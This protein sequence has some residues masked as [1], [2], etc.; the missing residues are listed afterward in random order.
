MFIK[1]ELVTFL[2]KDSA[3]LSDDFPFSDNLP[4][5]S[6]VFRYDSGIGVGH[7]VLCS[8][9]KIPDSKIG[10]LLSVDFLVQF[11]EGQ[12][13]LYVVSWRELD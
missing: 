6:Y 9:I 11:I 7:A 13:R 2:S 12:A 1:N 8:G 3:S 10:V 5:G 4:S